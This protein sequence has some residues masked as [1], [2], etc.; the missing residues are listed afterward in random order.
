MQRKTL[1]NLSD[2]KMLHLC[3]NYYS[4]NNALEKYFNITSK[5]DYCSILNIKASN[6]GL[7]W[8]KRGRIE[9]KCTVCKEYFSNQ[10]SQESITCSYS[11]SNTY[12]RSGKNNGNYGSGNNYRTICFEY[13][14]KEC[15]V[16]FENII[17]AVHHYDEDNTNN[18]PENLIPMC[19]TH[20]QYFHS[21]HKEE[22]LDIINTYRDNFIKRKVGQSG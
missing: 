3:D 19:P 9:K 18:L 6:L 16:C 15:I 7:E 2:D 8:K 14:K 11:C 1:K 4:A 21:R 10:K 13:H 17:I 22:V 5:G 20:H 12:F